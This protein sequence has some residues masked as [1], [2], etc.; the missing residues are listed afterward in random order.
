MKNRE[1]IAGMPMF[2]HHEAMKEEAMEAEKTGTADVEVV[3][4]VAGTVRASRE[5]QSDTLPGGKMVRIIHQGPYKACEPTCHKLFAWIA[6]KELKV[7]GP[8]REV[9]Y[10]D[11]REVTLEEILTEILAVVG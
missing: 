9:Y 5:V 2:L 3:V 1:T 8:I 6:K 7:K 4:P 11:P 10:N